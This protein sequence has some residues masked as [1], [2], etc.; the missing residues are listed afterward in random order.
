MLRTATEVI[1]ARHLWVL[2]LIACSAG[3]VAAQR[4]DARLVTPVAAGVFVMRHPDLSG[5]VHGNTTVVVGTREVLVVDSSFTA[6]MARE[7]IAEIRRRTRLPVRYLVNTHWHQDHTAGNA[8]YLDAFPGLAI[9][10]HPSTATMLANTSPT[11]ASDIRR[12]GV[13]YRKSVEERLASGTASNGQPLTDDQRTRLTRQLADI[14]TVF[15]QANV[16]RQQMP[17]LTTRGRLSVDLGDRVVDIAHVGRGNTAGD[18][19]VYLPKD[20][21]L[22]AGDLLVEPVPFTFDGY[23]GEWLET[24][25]TLRAWRADAVVPGHGEVQRDHVY[26]DQVIA[27]FQSVIDQVDAQLRRNTE[28]TL[29]EVTKAVDLTAMRARFAGD[30]LNRGANF[31]ATIGGRLVAIVYYEL[32][33]R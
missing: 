22:I 3:P 26:F 12:D 7:D 13:P 15:E 27:L 1:P 31:D 19:V 21:V 2:L 6:A 10:A 29:D 8:D 9:V 23:P 5:W 33:Q 14:D 30:D 24:L 11:L 18:L 32:K 4:L 16:Y 20:R 17:T 25:R 28:S